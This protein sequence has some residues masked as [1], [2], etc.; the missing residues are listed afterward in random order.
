M[1]RENQLD[2]EDCVE[3]QQFLSLLET[4][5]LRGGGAAAFLERVRRELGADVSAALGSEYLDELAV[6]V[7]AT[8]DAA[9]C[10]LLQLGQM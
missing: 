8:R 9:A 2:S 1:K 7:A 6:R 4:H 3:M 10:T 5:C